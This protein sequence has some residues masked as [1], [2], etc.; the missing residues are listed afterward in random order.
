MI[1][2]MMTLRWANDQKKINQFEIENKSHDQ[3]W[4]FS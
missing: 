4:F 1:K 3:E 2:A